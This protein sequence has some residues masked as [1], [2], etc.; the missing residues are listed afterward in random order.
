MN[1][2]CLNM[3]FINRDHATVQHEFNKKNFLQM[4]SKE[5]TATTPANKAYPFTVEVILEE[6]QNSLDKKLDFSP[7]ISRNTDTHSDAANVL[8][9]SG[10]S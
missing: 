5:K 7:N 8:N 1:F 10:I 6:E 3:I 9:S 4:Q 2:I